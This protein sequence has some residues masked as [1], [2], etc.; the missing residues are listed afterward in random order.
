MAEQSKNIKIEH[1]E[2]LVVV[3]I[4]DGHLDDDEREFLVDKAEEYG[5]HNKEIERILANPHQLSFHMPESQEEKEEQLS[6]VV[7]MAMIDGEIHEKEYALCV[8]FANRIGM[9]EKDVNEIIALAKKL[10]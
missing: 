10:F 7:F 8:S 1:F 9:T 5:I 4:A 3:A 2:N 6:D